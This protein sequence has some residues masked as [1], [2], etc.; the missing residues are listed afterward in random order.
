MP[1]D[2]FRWLKINFLTLREMTTHFFTLRET[3]VITQTLF[4]GHTTHIFEYTS[5]KVQKH[6]F[7]ENSTWIAKIKPQ[8]SFFEIA[9]R[10]L[11]VTQNQFSN[12]DRGFYTFFSLRE[13]QVITYNLFHGHMLIIF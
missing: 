2:D 6:D 4:H 10:R 3:Q 11:P 5:G 9:I 13:T 1:L 8:K 7:F 12:L